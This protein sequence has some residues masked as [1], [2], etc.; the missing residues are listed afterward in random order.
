MKTEGLNAA[1]KHFASFPHMRSGMVA[2][3][4]YNKYW[5]ASGSKVVSTKAGKAYQVLAHM[6][7]LAKETK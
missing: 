7:D 1:I 3:D 5:A 2:H 6:K 4:H